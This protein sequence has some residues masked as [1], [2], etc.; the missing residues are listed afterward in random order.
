M[1]RASKLSEQS[2]CKSVPLS[3]DD[4]EYLASLLTSQNVEAAREMDDG[5]FAR[6]GD[7]CAYRDGWSIDYYVEGDCGL[8]PLV[9]EGITHCSSC[10]NEEPIEKLEKFVLRKVG[11]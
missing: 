11:D 8:P 7:W 9:L 10:G 2:D 6:R 4:V 1:L 3:S 5:Y